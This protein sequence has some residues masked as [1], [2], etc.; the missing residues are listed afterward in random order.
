MMD[1]LAVRLILER[2]FAQKLCNKQWQFDANLDMFRWYFR[3]KSSEFMV[4]LHFFNEQLPEYLANEAQKLLEFSRHCSSGYC[5]WQ[6]LADLLWDWLHTTSENRL[7]GKNKAVYSIYDQ[8]WKLFKLS[9]HLAIPGYIVRSLNNQQI[10]DIF[11]I[12][13]QLTNEKRGFIWLQ[14]YEINYRETI[15]NMLA[16]NHNR[17]NWKERVQRPE[18]QTIF[19][20][21][22]R[23]EAFRRHMEEINPQIETFGAAAHYNVFIDY[24]GNTDD[25]MT[26]LCPVVA[27]PAHEIHEHASANETIANLELQNRFQLRKKV[28][29]WFHQNTRLGVLS[30]ALTIGL[31]APLSLFFLMGKSLLP[32]KINNL[33][34]NLLKRYEPTVQTDIDTQAEDIIEKPTPEHRQ[35]GFSDSEQVDRLETFLRNIGLTHNFSPLV[36]IFGHGSMSKNNP[37]LSAYDCGACSGRHSGPNA[38]ILAQF[39][40]RP[41]VRTLLSERGIKIPDDSLF[42][43]AEHNTCDESIIW[44]D[45]EKSDKQFHLAIEKLKQTIFH[46]TQLS[47]HERCRKLASAPKHPSLTQALKHIVERGVD[48]SQARPELGHATNACA[49]IGRRSLTQGAFLDRRSFLISYNPHEDPDGTIVERLLLANGPV[50][51]GI[52]LEYYFSTVDNERY[53]SGSKITHNVSG[54]FGVMDGNSSDLR[55]GLPRQMIEIHEAMR[56]QLIVEASTEVLTKIYQRQPAIQEL[57]GNGWILLCSID[58][59][60][61]ETF[62]FT[63]KNGFEPWAGQVTQLPTVKKSQD[64]Y[65]GYDCHLP[66]ALI[67]TVTV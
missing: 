63:P 50:G 53:G 19:C 64:W 4:R 18:A 12:F 31:S 26:R 13:T 36:V 51:A 22:D 56:L 20:M 15:L 42:I 23:E 52:S 44:Y 46:V 66:P 35:I 65:D 62:V 59:N 33:L 58:P 38:R 3:H 9:Q 47:A 60:S 17:G 11:S 40:N 5:D 32:Q 48:F 37:H 43:G 41:E 67:Q 16:N 2:V 7:D 21:D 49:F 6:N 57:V 8:A 14:A 28:I 39:A 27:I 29:N 34:E 25:Q 55:T 54:L 1:Y 61:G 45:I 24:Q 10:E 30:S